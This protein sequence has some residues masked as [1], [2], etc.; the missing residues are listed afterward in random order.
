MLLFLLNYC[1]LL[2]AQSKLNYYKGNQKLTIFKD[3]FKN[4]SNSWTIGYYRQTKTMF[5]V[6]NGYFMLSNSR[7]Y[8]SF[9]WRNF[10]IPSD[11]NFQIDLTFSLTTNLRNSGVIIEL[12]NSKSNF[13]FS[14]MKNLK[15]GNTFCHIYGQHDSLFKNFASSEIN[16]LNNNR[17]VIRKVSNEL[18]Y[19]LNGTLV[20]SSI[21]Q[22]GKPFDKIGIAPYWNSSVNIDSLK[23]LILNRR[24]NFDKNF[25]KT[26]SIAFLPV[27]SASFRAQPIADK[28]RDVLISKFK[29]FGYF[30]IIGNDY[31]YQAINKLHIQLQNMNKF[32]AIQLGKALGADIIIFGYIN[33]FNEEENYIGLISKV[34]YTADNYERSVSSEINL[35]GLIVNNGLSFTKNTKSFSVKSTGYK[36]IHA[37]ESSSNGSSNTTL[38]AIVDIL[39]TA[40][41]VA[42]ESPEQA[43]QRYR[44]DTFSN[45]KNKLINK[46]ADFYFFGLISS[47][48]LYNKMNFIKQNDSLQ[49]SSF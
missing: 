34:N 20:D 1:V 21:F 22:T 32:Q 9:S 18:Y 36:N 19:F 38:G 12:A 10:D 6:D 41:E 29:K 17:L 8:A 37:T 30:N 24:F 13:L 46:V 16:L 39:S 47:K 31:I 14:V 27:Q 48:D 43:S 42:S 33:D 11:Q 35:Q 26:I 28:L 44:L 25:S 3:D 7:K 45:L 2:P 49:N 15:R 5:K 23:I 4:N 40:V